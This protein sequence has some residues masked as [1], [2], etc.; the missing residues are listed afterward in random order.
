MEY[1]LAIIGAGAAGL[2]AAREAARAGLSVALLEARD[3]FGGRLHTI[4]DPRALA[5]IQLGGEFVHGRP[6]I[7]YGLLREF[8]A[9]VV[10]DAEGGFLFR[11]GA[12]Q[13]ATVDPF[14]VVTRLLATALE[15]HEDES[16]EDLIAR[17]LRTG[18]SP[19]AAAWTR[20]LVSGFDAADP[21]RASARAVAQEWVGDASAD[22]AQSRVLG[23]YAPLIAHLARTLDPVRVDVRLETVAKRIAWDSDGV[24]V[25]VRAH[26]R[27]A[28]FTAR[29]ALVTV[30]HGVLAASASN[31]GA[32]A[33]EPAL[34][35]STLD[36]IAHIAMGPVVKVVL[37][38]RNAVW[39]SL[40]GGVWRDGTFFNG[41]GIFPTFWTQL[42][43]RANTLVAWAGGPEADT[44]AKMG[45]DE[46]TALALECAGRYFGDARAIEAEFECAYQHDWQRDPFSR[47]AYTYT[48]VGGEGAREALA[49]PIE[50]RLWIA[51][52]AA[53]GAKE[54]GTVAGAL[55]SG[56]RAAREIV[57]ATAE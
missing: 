13:A 41:D 14:D 20:H 2:L 32:I 46:R 7:T 16:V 31:D 56:L 44:L 33:F 51:G 40:N 54:G 8:G 12:L 11:D 24:R 49:A 38:F 53:A 3:R 15:R 19:E 30:P 26:G 9:T 55:E 34:P 35:E 36:A 39:E 45:D 18:T 27:D 37:R 22:G 50:G 57:A 29:R 47:G 5:P 6:A 1:D 10:D 43:V 21:S 25:D 28:S 52:E 42:P 23:G 4:V 17:A 48:L